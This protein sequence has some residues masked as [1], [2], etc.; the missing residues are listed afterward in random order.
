MWYTHLLVLRLMTSTFRLFI[1]LVN[2]GKKTLVTSTVGP[3]P[4]RTGSG[5][6]EKSVGWHRRR[7]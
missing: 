5:G 7:G 2:S 1:D 4:V 3:F 6:P